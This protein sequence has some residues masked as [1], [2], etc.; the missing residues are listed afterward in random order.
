[1]SQS[2][3]VDKL[4]ELGFERMPDQEASAKIKAIRAYVLEPTEGVSR[5]P[6]GLRLPMLGENEPCFMAID[7]G[8][9]GVGFSLTVAYDD[10]GQKWQK[11]EVVDLEPFGFTN[12]LKGMQMN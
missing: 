3:Y 7:G 9:F 2:K 11:R 6:T 8:I 5:P 12:G 1:M 4:E 10:R